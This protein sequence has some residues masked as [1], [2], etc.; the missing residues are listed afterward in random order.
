LLAEIARERDDLDVEVFGGKFARGG[1]RRVAAAVLHIDRLRR[2]AALRPERAD[3]LHDAGV[4]G[5]EDGGPV[6]QG[7]HE[8]K[9]GLCP[10]AARVAVGG[11]PRGGVS[12]TAAQRPP[13]WPCARRGGGNAQSGGGCRGGWLRGGGGPSAWRPGR[14]KGGP[15]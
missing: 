4:Q 6:E 3:D 13:F 7:N 5:P 15:P 12:G 10:P 8:R 2:Q 11:G 9:A 14:A 1:K